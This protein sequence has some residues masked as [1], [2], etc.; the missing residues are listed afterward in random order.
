MKYLHQP[1][2]PQDGAAPSLTRPE[3]K[4][5]QLLETLEPAEK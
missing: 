2:N 3:A 1:E 4:V 5:A